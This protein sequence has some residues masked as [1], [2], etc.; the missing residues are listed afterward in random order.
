MK[1]AIA[2]G[3]DDPAGTNIVQ[4]LKKFSQLKIPIIQLEK[5]PIYSDNIDSE[6]YPELKNI[7]FLIFASTHK[8]EKNQPSLSVHAPGNWHKADLGG[9]PGK[10]CETNA[11]ILKY[12]FQQLNKNA[13]PLENKY[14]ITLECTHHGPYIEKPCCFIEIGS[15]KEQWQDKDAGKIIAKTILSLQNYK[16]STW[17]PIIAIGGPHYAPSFT[18]VQ[19]NSSYATGHIIPQYALPLTEDMLKEAIE[20][21]IEP[22]KLVLL[23]WKGCGK[24]KERHKIIE[25]IEQADLKYK[26]TS[27]IEK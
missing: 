10:I 18:K 2:Y 13:K 9:K 8:S 7:D 20:K 1:F 26:R 25:L 19:L 21:T 14:Q 6:K 27:E 5:H 17:T 22:V 15:T 16:E 4:H 11:F 23:D 3:K 12:L 24:S